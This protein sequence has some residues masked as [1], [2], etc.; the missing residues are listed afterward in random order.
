RAIAAIGR[1]DVDIAGLVPLEK[2]IDIIGGSS[3]HLLLDLTDITEKYRVGDRVRF[4]MNYSALL[5]AMRPGGSIHK[6]I[7]R[8]TVPAFL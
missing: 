2:G 7:L 6:N 8:D 3:D 1:G 4:S 5:Q